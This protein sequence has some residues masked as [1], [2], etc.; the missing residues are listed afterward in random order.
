MAKSPTIFDYTQ[1][2]SSLFRSL[3]ATTINGVIVI[4]ERGTIEVYS[5]ACEQLFQYRR[6]ETLGKNVSM[7]MPSPLRE[8][9]DRYIQRYI[10]TGEAHVIGIGRETLA[11]RK[12]G[13]TFPIY[14]S[15]GEGQI[16]GRRVFIGVVQ[17]LT[18]LHRERAVHDAQRAHLALIV[19]S[20][21]D[22][23]VSY[24]QDGAVISWNRAAASLYGYA[25]DEVTG[26]SAASLIQSTVSPDRI[27]DEKKAMANALSGERGPPYQS[28]HL[29]KDG[30]PIHVFV[31]VSPIQDAHGAIVGAS[32]TIRDMSEHMALEEKKALLS[33]VV[34][35]SNDAI[36]TKTLD[37]V[38]TSCNRAAEVLFGYA[39]D[40]LV[41]QPLLRLFP[42]ERAREEA[43][44]VAKVRVGEPV[45][46]PETVRLRKNGTL[47]DVSVAV[48]PIRG[49]DR[50]VIG[51][52]GTIRDITERKASDARIQEL[53]SEL[54][55]VARVSEMSQI[56]AGIAHELNQPLAAIVN[57]INVAKRLVANEDRASIAK[58]YEA[59]V[60]AGDQAVR[61]GEIVRRLRGFVEKRETS[62]APENINLIIEDAIALGLIGS[63]AAN[64]TTRIELAPHPAP[65][66][67][68]RIQ[69]EQ[70]LVN[71]L[72][73]AIEAMATSPRRELVLS[74]SEADDGMEV[75]V[76]DTGLGIAPDVAENL[77][78]PFVSTKPGGM[79]IGL[80]I[81]RSIIE[82][83]GGLLTVSPN[84]GGGTVFRFT[85][86]LARDENAA[87]LRA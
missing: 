69:I 23:I 12:D 48:F 44:I 21:S 28:I 72:R 66:F 30:S 18:I 10:S 33:S 22:A 32:S 38:V 50:T 43:E 27:A 6:D 4:D 64:I 52:A 29:R 46:K 24:T 17:D 82:A 67:A 16:A 73:N 87:A 47:I 41:G 26:R 39:T 9:H 14:L 42:P 3:I 77:F 20:S 86:P 56:S 8:D 81:S 2:D 45:R 60:K 35:S 62:V 7:L 71:L 13:T 1:P 59:I 55:H 85:L 78:K 79:G 70:V 53:R 49:A 65:V 61:T 37:G 34:E 75:A 57:Y 51:A 54:T 5:D 11:Q 84:I 74:T 63:S 31:S 83:H 58:A 36:Y 68:D 19:D 25:A 15:V 80:A 76:A 40:E